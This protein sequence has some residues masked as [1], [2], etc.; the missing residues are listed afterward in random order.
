MYPQGE[1]TT[2]ASNKELLRRR[3][4]RQRLACEAAAAEVARPLAWISRALTTWRKISPMVKLGAVALGLLARRKLRR[5]S[6]LLPALFR[7][8]PLALVLARALGGMRKGT[9][10][11]PA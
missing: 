11:T 3:I 1:L 8:A 6:R 7:L 9:P 10:G 5:R 4:A 2:L